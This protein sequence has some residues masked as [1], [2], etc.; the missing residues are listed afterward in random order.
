MAAMRAARRVT[1][2]RRQIERLT[3]GR[4]HASTTKRRTA[5]ARTS[6]KD[7]VGKDASVLAEA[8]GVQRP[9]R[10][11]TPL[12]R[13]GRGPSVRRA[14]AD[15]AVRARSSASRT[16]TTAIEPGE[17]REH[18]YR[19]TAIIHSRNIETITK[20]G[21]G[22]EH[23]AVRAQRPEHGGR[24][25]CGGQGYLSYSIATPTGEGITTPLTFTR[26]R[27]LA[28]GAGGLRII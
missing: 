1:A 14:R 15:D 18:G 21:R 13:D 25:G 9:R 16:S 19:H 5:D 4:V 22:H 23:D 26:E 10:H 17:K 24:S 8:A 7:L 27:Q 6:N 28:I 3:Q 12:R 20:M 2:R 11:A